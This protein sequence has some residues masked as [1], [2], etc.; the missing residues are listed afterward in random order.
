[1]RMDDTSPV[2]ISDRRADSDFIIGF[3]RIKRRHLTLITENRRRVVAFRRI[4]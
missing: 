2:H 3:L 4:V 1:M